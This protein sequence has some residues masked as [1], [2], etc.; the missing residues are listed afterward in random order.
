MFVHDFF[1]SPNLF[2]SF[3]FSFT[4]SSLINNINHNIEGQATNG[5]CHPSGG[6]PCVSL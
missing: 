1:F 4:S 2:F 3:C 5:Y 6:Q